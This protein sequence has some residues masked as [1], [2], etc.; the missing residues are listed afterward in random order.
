VDLERRNK[1][2]VFVVL[3]TKLSEE[4]NYKEVGVLGVYKSEEQANN[5]SAEALKALKVDLVEIIPKTVE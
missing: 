3:G 1:M 4:D 5:V 2:K